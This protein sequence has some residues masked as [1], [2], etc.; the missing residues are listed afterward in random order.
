MSEPAPETI[1]DMRLRSG[2]TLHRHEFCWTPGDT[3]E[4]TP[5]DRENLRLL[6]DLAAA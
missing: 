1:R 2:W 5:E 3:S 6:K 4:L